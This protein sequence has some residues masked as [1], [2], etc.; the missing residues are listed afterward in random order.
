MS[1]RSGQLW[2]KWEG[3][4]LCLASRPIFGFGEFVGWRVVSIDLGCPAGLV[5]GSIV[6]AASVGAGG[7]VI[8]FVF[9]WTPWIR[10]WGTWYS[11]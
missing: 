5:V 10:N 3:T 2:R 11:P 7:A 6:W 4:V 9:G 8:D 1:H